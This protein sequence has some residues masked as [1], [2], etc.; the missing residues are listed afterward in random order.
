MYGYVAVAY[1]K[2][3]WT[4]GAINPPPP[5]KKE[6]TKTYF[7]KT[8][9]YVENSHHKNNFNKKHICLKNSLKN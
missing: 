2:G 7:S 6:K 8:Q 9:K 3:G 5:S 4:K 1:P